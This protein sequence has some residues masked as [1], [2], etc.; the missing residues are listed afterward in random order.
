MNEDGR[1][2]CLYKFQGIGWSLWWKAGG[3]YV[4]RHAHLH[5][6]GLL[7]ASETNQRKEFTFDSIYI[8]WFVIIIGSIIHQREP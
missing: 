4:L 8:Q 6:D 7:D 5:Q 3:G 1:T 2:F